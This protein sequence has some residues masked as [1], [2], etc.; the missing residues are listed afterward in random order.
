MTSNAHDAVSDLDRP[1]VYRLNVGL[2]KERFRELFPTDATP[3]FAA[4][5][6]LLPHPVYGRQYWVSVLNPDVTWPTVARFLREAHERAVRRYE[7][8]QP[9]SG[10]QGDAAP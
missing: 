1:G 4:L 7:N 2:P 3:D 5:D 8:A 9:R 10:R 6:T